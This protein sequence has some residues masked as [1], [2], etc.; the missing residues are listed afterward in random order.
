MIDLLNF[1]V[2]DVALP[3]SVDELSSASG[4]GLMHTVKITLRRYYTPLLRV[5]SQLFNFS[6]LP[7]VGQR[8]LALLLDTRSYD[9][10]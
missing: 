5:T 7:D 10:R 8:R 1:L 9:W 3:P 2:G 4:C 6:S